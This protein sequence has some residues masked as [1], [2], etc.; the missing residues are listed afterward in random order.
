[1]CI[2]DRVW[3]QR[4]AEQGVVHWKIDTTLKDLK[5]Y[6]DL[7]PEEDKKTAMADVVEQLESLKAEASAQ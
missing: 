4:I 6:F 3:L 1:M 7:M 2:R 5:D